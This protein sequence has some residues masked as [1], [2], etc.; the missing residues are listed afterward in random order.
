MQAVQYSDYS[1]N[2]DDL[3][4]VQVPIPVPGKGQVLVRIYFAAMNHI[5]L[6]LFSGMLRTSNWKVDLPFIPGYEFSGVVDAVGEEATKFAVGDEV[7]AVNWENGRHNSKVPDSLEPVGGCF[8]EYICLSEARLSKK[9]PD[10]SFARAACLSM[11]GTAALQCLD[12]I[13][14]V[15]TGSRVLIIGG[16]MLVGS[17]AIQLA[18]QR[19]AFVVSAQRPVIRETGRLS[20]YGSMRHTWESTPGADVVVN[21]EPA[22]MAENPD[23]RGFDFVLD[24]VGDPETLSVLKTTPGMVCTGAAYVNL[25][26]PAVGVL[27]QAHP[28]FSYARFYCFRQDSAQQD[29]IAKL[30][31]EGN[32]HIPIYEIFPFSKDGIVKM[33]RTMAQRKHKGKLL[34]EIFNPDGGHK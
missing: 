29:V 11:I 5:D 34:L 16:G 15:T 30:V 21:C 18:K 4:L 3:V 2:P 22:A 6:I 28:P 14:Y 17:V 10:M 12:E 33:F 26:N 9:P 23:C 27:Q 24:I 32:L 20:R 25:V 13:G 7:F 19:G 8:T 1:Q 31:D